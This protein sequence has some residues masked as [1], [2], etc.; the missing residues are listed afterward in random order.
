MFKDLPKIRELLSSRNN[1][2]AQFWF[3]DPYHRIV[4][5]HIFSDKKVL[6]VDAEDTFTVMLA[7][8]LSAIGLKVTIRHYHEPNLLKGTWNLIILGPGPGDPR[9]I[10]MHRII[11]MRETIISLYAQK[12]PFF[13]ICLSH[14][15]LCLILGFEIVQLS[16][17]KQGVQREIN[18]FGKHELVGFYNTFVAKNKDEMLSK[19]CQLSIEVCYDPLTQNIHALKGPDF[20]SLQ[21]HPESILTQNG[22]NIIANSIEEI[23][24]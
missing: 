1:T 15:L 10:N 7:Q 21:F 6:M 22:I 14:Q 8:L 16:E 9:N 11:R 18:L 24:K 23:I 3:S 5:N 2:L 19:M 4:S 12:V 17:P 20:V 13:A